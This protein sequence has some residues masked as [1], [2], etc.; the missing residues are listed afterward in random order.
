MFLLDELARTIRWLRAFATGRKF[1]SELDEEMSFH[2]EMLERDHAATGLAQSEAHS[3]AS[4][5]FG[6]VG[7]LREEASRVWGLDIRDALGQDFRFAFRTLR[8]S[9]GFALVAIATLAVAVGLSAA[10][11]TVVY[12]VLL[13]PLPVRDGGRL[14]LIE[15]RASGDPSLRPFAVVDLV[16]LSERKETFSDVAGVQ[17]DGGFPYPMRD[18]DRVSM[19]VGSI[20]SSGFFRVLGVRPAAGRLFE[21]SDGI[22]GAPV[23]AVISYALWQRRYGGDP[24]V[25]GRFVRFIGSSPVII[26]VAPRGFEY[27][28]GVELWV[29]KRFDKDAL[30]SRA[31]RP[32]AI[33]ARLNPRATIGDARLAAAEFTRA[34][35]VSYGPDEAKGQR[36]LVQPLRDAI[37]GGARPSIVMLASA[38][39]LLFFLATLNVANILLIRTTGRA[40]EMAIRGALGAQRNR[41]V[42]QLVTESGLLAIA[43]TAVGSCL[44]FLALRLFVLLA[45]IDLPR[46]RDIRVDIATLATVL[47]GGIACVIVA[48]LIPSVAILRADKLDSIRLGSR[49]GGE[50]RATRRLKNVLVISQVA[51]AVLLLTAAGLLTRSYAALATS[52]PGYEAS[53]VTL[54]TLAIPRE[55]GSSKN[56]L[57]SFY[58]E[59]IARLAGA[60]GVVSATPVMI[61]PFTGSGGWDATY[62]LP[63]QSSA[64]AAINPTLDL[65][66]VAPGYFSTLGIQLLRGR[67]FQEGD[68]DSAAPVAILSAAAAHRAWPEADP[69]GQRIKTGPPDGPEP[70]RTVVGIVRD[71]RYRDV[72]V[73]MPIIYIPFAQVGGVELLPSYLAIRSSSPSADLLATVRASVHDVDNSTSAVEAHSLKQLMRVPLARPRLNSALLGVFALFSLLLAALGLYGSLSEIVEQRSH[74]FGVRM[75]LGAQSSDVWRAVV[76]RGLALAVVGVAAGMVST[77]GARRIL[78]SLLYGVPPNDPQTTAFVIVVLLLICVLATLLPARR[79]LRIDPVRALRG[80]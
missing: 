74:E 5:Q 15:K 19:V 53:G 68:R 30:T 14:V 26:G 46:L 77:L 10:M 45:P 18:G 49:A 60:R 47:V 72:T 21:P 20:V 13:R 42:R 78:H 80:E 57:F 52:D 27:P 66:A 17:Y 58:E 28:R 1:R 48:G 34:Q 25:V 63:G 69:I 67:G 64:T 29:A 79:A 44:A 62:S 65:Q 16:A 59:L 38:V 76:A 39:A 61:E 11:V 36:P 37:V 56:R 24:S 4:K 50:S 23:A 9:P 7:A 32:F 75:A 55:L 2:L 3:A 71:T 51:M 8:R 12:D 6:R 33:L 22:D 41:L 40:R 73:A 35:E 70:W 54:V 43:A 31:V